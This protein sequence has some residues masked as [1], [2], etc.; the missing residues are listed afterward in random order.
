M[1]KLIVIFVLLIC[2]HMVNAQ[3]PGLP[4]GDPDVPIDEN[5]WLILTTVL[6]CLLWIYRTKSFKRNG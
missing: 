4:G 2:I 5:G 1:K 3:D 6:L